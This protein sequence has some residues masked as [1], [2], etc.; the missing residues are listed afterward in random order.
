MRCRFIGWAG[1]ELEHAGETLVIDPL[2][3]PAAVFAAVGSAAHGVQYPVVRPPSDGVASAGLVTH[4]HRDHA[5]AG[6]LVEALRPGA[7]ILGP[8]PA[9][10]ASSPS[11]A[12]LLQA[13]DEFVESGLKLSELAPWERASVGPFEITALPAADGTGDPQVSWAVAAGNKR[14]VHCGD[15]L[16]HGWWWRAAETAGPFDAAFVP[17]N[18][19]VL[20][21]PWRQPRSERPGVMTPEEAVQA[22]RA[23]GAARAVPFHYGGFDLAPHYRSIPDALERFLT[24]AEHAGITAVPLSLGETLEL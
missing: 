19:A 1:V 23:L 24:A 17:I 16:F 2:A 8:A 13:C 10:R 12:G 14:I 15:T 4:L 3:K 20:D 7:P 9:P 21:F 22:V 6:A 18:G 11:D 5:D